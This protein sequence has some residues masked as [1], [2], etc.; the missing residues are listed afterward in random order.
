MKEA[1]TQISNNKMLEDKLKH[2]ISALTD[3]DG[4]TL[5]DSALR[6]EIQTLA[7]EL[8]VSD[9]EN[10]DKINDII[11]FIAE[12]N[13]AHKTGS[14]LGSLAQKIQELAKQSQRVK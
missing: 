3:A 8:V 9:A 4:K 1:A 7:A 14:H 5:T 2:L 13:I 11:S 6:D 12:N 10:K